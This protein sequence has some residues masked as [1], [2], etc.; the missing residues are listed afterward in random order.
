MRNRGIRVQVWLNDK[1]NSRLD[2]NALKA[3]LSRESYL[4][5]LIN[6][7]PKA[8]YASGLRITGDGNLLLEIMLRLSPKI[9]VPIPRTKAL[10][11]FVLDI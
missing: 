8:A 1:E 2:D 5:T 11:F 10:P 6:S 4:R 3:G 9:L 7:E